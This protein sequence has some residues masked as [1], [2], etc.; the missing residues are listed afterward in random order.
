MKKK[1]DLEKLA[2]I[3][4]AFVVLLHGVSALEEEHGN[5][6]F[7]FIAGIV[8]LI[9]AVYHHRIEMKLPFMS[10]GFFLIEAV[11]ILFISVHYFE[12]GKKYLPY[13]Y[14]A[15]ALMYFFLGTGI[16]QSKRKKK[17]T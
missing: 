13:V 9:F 11:V 17:H 5:P 14:F 4:S 15:C 1:A 10:N 6:V 16:I 2:H 8:M 12:I 7:Y 3:L